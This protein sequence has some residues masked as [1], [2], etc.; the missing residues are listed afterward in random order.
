MPSPLRQLIGHNSSPT[1]F[2]DGMN[3][4]Q[5][6]EQN[7]IPTKAITR[8]DYRRQGGGRLYLGS[9]IL[10]NVGAVAPK[11]A[12]KAQRKLAG[13]QRFLKSNPE[14]LRPTLTDPST[15]LH[16]RETVRKGLLLTGLVAASGVTAYEV[17]NVQ[18]D[19][20]PDVISVRAEAFVAEYG[21]NFSGLLGSGTTDEEPSG[22]ELVLS[23]SDVETKRVTIGKIVCTGPP[24]AVEAEGTKPDYQDYLQAAED[25]TGEPFG[26]ITSEDTARNVYKKIS[27]AY[28]EPVDGSWL[29]ATECNDQLEAAT[30]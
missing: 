19:I 1:G 12:V 21:D 23:G 14:V 20:R 25:K 7:K 24:V 10:Q 22:G 6:T 30:K 5:E 27:A 8:S 9:R 11:T 16:R 2:V 18:H 15:A 17:Q 28:G 4:K 13:Q 3:L 29:T 26:Q